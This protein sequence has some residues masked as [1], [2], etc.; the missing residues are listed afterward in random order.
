MVLIDSGSFRVSDPSPAGSKLYPA[1][2]PPAPLPVIRAGDLITVS[3]QT[4][5]LRA[6]FQAVAL[7]SGAAGQT[8]RVRLLG[9]S[10][11]LTGNQGTVVDVRAIQAG[12][13][14]WLPV[15]RNSQ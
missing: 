4:P 6:H 5:I 1:Q 13:A 14:V 9:G 8:L 7:E 2:L 11:T 3:Q 10:E 12:E 15:G